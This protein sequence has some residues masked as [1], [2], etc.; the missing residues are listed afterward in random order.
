ME[1]FQTARLENYLGQALAKDG[2]VEVHNLQD[3][4]S[5]WQSQI[6]SFDL[7][8]TRR[9][10]I[11]RQGCVA[12]LFP[13]KLAARQ[14]AYE[15]RGMQ[16][17]KK[18]DY[19]V[20]EVFIFC[21]DE[22]VMGQPFLIM[23]RIDG[24]L[25]IDKITQ[26]ESASQRASYLD[27]FCKLFV[28]LHHLD[29][30]PFADD[31]FQL[32]SSAPYQFID[33]W[34]RDAKNAL[35][36]FSL[37]GAKDI[38]SWVADN[39]LRSGIQRASV[40]HWDFHPGN[41]IMRTEQSPV[42]IDWSGWKIS[43]FRFDLSWTLLLATAYWGNAERDLILQLYEKHSG[44]MVEALD[45]FEVTACARR[46][47]DVLGSMALGADS[48]G[49]RPEAVHLMQAQI[50]HLKIVYDL[51]VERTGIRIQEIELVFE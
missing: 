41:I 39:R 45:V 48:F 38:I 7:H 4:T 44:R 35:E 3:I 16:T 42:V 36:R 34:L 30:R 6:L 19:P 26:A 51:F 2:T 1:N 23:E 27:L 22:Q 40:L 50:D 14:A 49:M 21:T 47:Y 20:P 37:P 8:V 46:L 17:L 25:L 11:T 24:P 15:F 10:S 28:N 9:G 12:R 43:D 31:S 5:G 33:A 18:S 32:E 13:G 29:W